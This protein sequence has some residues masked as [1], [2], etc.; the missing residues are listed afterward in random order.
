M[1]SF[2]SIQLILILVASTAFNAQGQSSTEALKDPCA[3]L[4][5]SFITSIDGFKKSNDGRK[6]LISSDTW[7]VCDFLVDNNF[8]SVSLKRYDDRI[9]ERKGVEST[10]Q[11]I[12]K[13]Q[14]QLTRAEVPN[15]PG[16]QAIYTYGKT[17]TPGK[18]YNFLLQWRYGNHTEG[19]IS[20]SYGK[21]QDADDMLNRL[22]KLAEKLD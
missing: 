9:I 18:P 16:D 4:S 10:Y 2:K 14:D 19:Q 6:N 13:T 3:L 22:I 21:K 7:K 15:A 17:N 8:L 1:N 11:R 5:S 12:L 20:I